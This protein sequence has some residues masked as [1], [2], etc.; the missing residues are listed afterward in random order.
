MEWFKKVVLENY[1]NFNGRARRMEFW[2]FNLIAFAISFVLSMVDQFS[3]LTKMTGGAGV[4]SLLF[5]LALLI[6]SIAVSV[7]RLHDTG[8]S[9]FLLLLAFIP[10][11]GAL[12]LLVFF[13]GESEPGTN[14]YGPNPLGNEGRRKRRDDFDD[15]DEDDDRRPRR[16]RDDDFE[17]EE[18]RR[19]RRPNRDDD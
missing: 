7:R 1:A 18:P 16:N 9:G 11:L 12:I 15:R 4:L 14:K 17:D 3:G 10:C 19:N 2:M 8:K 13:V 5:G 6:P